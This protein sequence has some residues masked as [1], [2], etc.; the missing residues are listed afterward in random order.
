LIRF[1]KLFSKLK[2]ISLLTYKV[3]AYSVIPDF[4]TDD[5]VDWAIEML[6]LGYETP[7]LLI[8][9]GLSKP[10]NYFET[11]D[12]LTKALN[13][14]GIK[15]KYGSEAILSYSG[16]F[17]EIIAEGKSIKSNLSSLCGLVQSFNYSKLIYD[18]YL[19]SWAWGD[20]DYGN[21]YTDYWPKATK[22]N[23]EAIVV[24]KAKEW[25]EKNKTIYQ[26]G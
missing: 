19:L 15:L 11:I 20:F 25:L 16:Y 10:T 21:E 18:F 3:I 17:V 24:T 5:C 1:K 9:A 22:E 4:N 13:E 26:L 14:L 23:I 6:E 12:Y 2:S 7:A 8:L